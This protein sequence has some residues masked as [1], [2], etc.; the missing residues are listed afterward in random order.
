M[1]KN[2]LYRPLNIRAKDH[3]VLFWGC[4]HFHHDPTWKL[5][6]WAIRGAASAREAVEMLTY[7]WSLK[8][9]H[10]TIGFLLGDTIFGYDAEE[11]LKHILNQMLFSKLYLM[12]GNH[13][14][15]WKQ[16]FEQSDNGIYTAD[17]GGEVIFVPNYLEAKVN[18][19]PIAMCHYPILSWNGQAKGSWM[20]F[21]HVHGKLNMSQ[22]G[23]DYLA[24][25][26]NREVSVEACPHP[27]TFGE[28]RAFMQARE[29]F[30]PDG[31]E[32]NVNTP[33]S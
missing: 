1:I 4:P 19:Q 32:S 24:K 2:L 33:F 16:L 14:A 13:T 29:R 30:V 18:G 27:V 12:P 17:H 3:Q 6:I 25:G 8:A 10:E 28:M 20:L 26:F 22:L 31:H 23:R 5:P 7:R 21:S 9:S 11:R 15:G